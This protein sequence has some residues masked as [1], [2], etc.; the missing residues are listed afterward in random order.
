MRKTITIAE[1]G[2]IRT[3]GDNGKALP[4]KG[5]DGVK[6]ECYRQPLFEHLKV[7]ATV[8]CEV[9][10]KP[11]K[12]GRFTN[13]SIQGVFQD[14]QPVGAQRQGGGQDGGRSYGKSPETEAMIQWHSDRRTLVMQVPE[15]IKAAMVV[16]QD[17][18]E[19]AFRIMRE[20]ANAP[21]NAPAG[22]GI[23]SEAKPIPTGIPQPRTSRDA[24]RELDEAFEGTVAGGSL[25][26]KAV[27]DLYREA[28]KLGIDSQAVNAKLG[29]K[30]GAD[31]LPIYGT[32][33]AAWEK[34]RGNDVVII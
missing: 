4:V 27:I 16:P 33:Q 8:E 19:A 3:F 10:D 11:S 6:Y 18:H 17:I 12:V 14:G 7:G 21:Q 20:W 31:I 28:A 24:A 30:M 15:Y 32:Y 26:I 29:V 22:Q 5:E 13:H 23:P 2:E 34:V 9:E 1:V 25:V